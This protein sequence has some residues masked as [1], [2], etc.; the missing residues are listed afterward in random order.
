[1]KLSPVCMCLK[2]NAAFCSCE[3]S[4]S[5]YGCQCYLCVWVHYRKGHKPD[6]CLACK[7]VADIAVWAGGNNDTM[8]SEPFETFKA[9]YFAN[10]LGFTPEKAALTADTVPQ[11]PSL[12]VGSK[13]DGVDEL[14]FHVGEGKTLKEKIVSLNM[15]IPKNR[16]YDRYQGD[17]AR[18]TLH[19]LI[20]KTPDKVILWNKFYKIVLEY[21]EAK[22]IGKDN[23]FT[24]LVGIFSYKA[25]ISYTE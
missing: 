12:H 13:N 14:K 18:Q 8:M 23:D 17:L 22:K 5:H 1:M 10:K 7:A 16:I 4:F 24:T 25:L 2:G 6:G 9:L 19:L 20:E 15:T 11:S 21:L 3:G